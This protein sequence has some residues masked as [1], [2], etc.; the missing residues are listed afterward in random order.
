MNVFL[1][2]MNESHMKHT[3]ATHHISL[4]VYCD[5]HSHCYNITWNIV[6]NNFI[7]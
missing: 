6:L 7:L 5:E 3:T 1:I 4:K 2:S